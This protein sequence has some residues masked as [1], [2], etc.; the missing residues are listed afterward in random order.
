MKML[1]SRWVLAS[2]DALQVQ[3]ASA[4]ISSSPTLPAM[5]R[6]RPIQTTDADKMAEIEGG[7]I[8]NFIINDAENALNSCFASLFQS[9]ILQLT[10]SLHSLSS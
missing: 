8:V 1:K 5:A 6:E 10:M 4:T 7:V 3:L 2:V 9:Q